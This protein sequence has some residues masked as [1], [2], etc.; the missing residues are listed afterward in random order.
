VG[1]GEGGSP[2]GAA[3]GVAGGALTRADEH[4]TPFERA[5][6]LAI[7]E[8]LRASLDPTNAAE[9][10]L[11]QMM[12]TAVEQQLRWQTVATRRTDEQVWQGEQDVRRALERMSPRERE[13]H[14]EL[15]GWLP[16]RQSA[17]EAIEQAVMIADRYQRQ[18]CGCSGRCRACGGCWGP[19]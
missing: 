19:S 17:A 16:P 6:Y 4:A 18:T 13:R 8:G 1:R 14:Q 7:L 9:E 10:L 2:G 12:A 3:D 5:Q 15:E 11:V